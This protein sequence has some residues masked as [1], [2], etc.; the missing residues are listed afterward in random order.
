MPPKGNYPGSR[1]I[2]IMKERRDRGLLVEARI[3]QRVKLTRPVGQ[4]LSGNC[5]RWPFLF[6]RE[7]ERTP[8]LTS[9]IIKEVC[10][11]PRATVPSVQRQLMCYGAANEGG[12]MAERPVDPRH[13]HRPSRTLL[14]QE[15]EEA[16]SKYDDPITRVKTGARGKGHSTSAEMRAWIDVRSERH[17]RG[18]NAGG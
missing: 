4:I 3:R 18:E 8:P 12:D 17:R 16:M 2:L 14:R 13:K 7:G 10:F 9:L 6:D 11:F 1:I 5:C 15:L